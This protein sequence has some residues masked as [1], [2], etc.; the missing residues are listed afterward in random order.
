MSQSS[1]STLPQSWSGPVRHRRPA[2]ALLMSLVLP[3]FGQLYNG[4]FNKAIWLF[5]CFGLLVTPGVAG[6]A[7]LLPSAAMMPALLACTLTVL[8]LWLYAA[9]DA[10]RTAQ[11]LTHYRLAAWQASG[12]YALAFLLCD[13]LALPLLTSY[14]RDH[15][16]ASYR[17]P[18]HSMEPGILQGDILFA[19]RR[20]NCPGCT[21]A[22][23]R[24]DV[25]IFTYPNDRTQNYIKRVIGLPGDRVRIHGRAVWV[26]DVP[27]TASERPDGTGVLV[28]EQSGNRQ[29]TVRWDAAATPAPDQELSV[30]PG[31]ALVLGDNRS[32][33]KDTREFGT[34]PLQ[35]ITGKAR[36]VWLSLEPGQGV[37][38]GRLG[39]VIE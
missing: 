36:Q 16:V 15:Q 29:W 33:S 35:D 28:R 17:I 6:I 25:A 1:E 34:V 19:D 24:G 11:G 20:Y 32:R 7:L 37:R 9:T 21:S 26:N 8:G 38:W 39:A 22:V 31:Q 18:S 4:Q 10:W 3:G 27:L 12:V 13:G 2:F 14:I 5:L 23:A 30:P